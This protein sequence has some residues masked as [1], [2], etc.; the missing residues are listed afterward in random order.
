MGIAPR[1]LRAG[2]GTWS[3]AKSEACT[4]SGCRS[5]NGPVP[6]PLSMKVKRQSGTRPGSV[7]GFLRSWPMTERPALSRPA[8]RQR[9]CL[10]KSQRPSFLPREIH[11]RPCKIGRIR[12]NLL[13]PGMLRRLRDKT[14][15]VAV[16]FRRT[17]K[18][19]R[20]R[21]L[22]LRHRQRGE[23]FQRIRR[24]PAIARARARLA[25]IR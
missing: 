23:R 2:F 6:Q 16:R 12:E 8:Q 13:H 11:F 20:A 1:H 10:F 3:L 5:V 21:V 22:P 19:C 18:P 7:N 25:G 4:Q 15:A 24:T 14:R 17:E 9:H